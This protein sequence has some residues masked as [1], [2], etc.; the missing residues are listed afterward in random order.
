MAAHIAWVTLLYAALTLARAPSVWGVFQLSDGSNPCAAVEG[1]IS[2]NLR[3][4]FEWPLLFYVVCLLLLMQEP[5][6]DDVQA[7]FA[8]L[9]VA[10][11]VI[12]TAVQVL[13]TSIRLRGIVF[14]VNFVAVLAMW[15]RFLSSWGQA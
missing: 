11:R 6:Q 12:H 5:V 9:F 15:I 13:G 10:G 1:R 3:N 2:A 4:Q 7:V 14:T 8:W